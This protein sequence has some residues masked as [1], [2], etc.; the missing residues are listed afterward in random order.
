MV[1]LEFLDN[2]VI[3]VATGQVLRSS[4]LR[5]CGRPLI[6][7]KC[8]H[9][10]TNKWQDFSSHVFRALLLGFSSGTFGGGPCSSRSNFGGVH[11]LA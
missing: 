9:Y 2:F 11:K 5:T 10:L 8:R 4:P 3:P 6:E 1:L 7:Y